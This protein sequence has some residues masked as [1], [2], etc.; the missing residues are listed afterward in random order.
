MTERMF[1][2]PKKRAIIPLVFAIVVASLLIIATLVFTI[3]AAVQA[4]NYKSSYSGY[5]SYS[6]Y[7]SYS[8]IY[9]MLP[10][11]TFSIYSLITM[12]VVAPILSVFHLTGALDEKNRIAYMRQNGLSPIDPPR[13]KSLAPMIEAGILFVLSLIFSV[14]GA[15][16]TGWKSYNWPAFIGFIIVFLIYSI[17][18]FVIACITMSIDDHNYIMATGRADSGASYSYPPA[19]TQGYA[20]QQYPVT[21]QNY[22]QTAPVYGQQA[23]QSEVPSTNYPVN[24]Q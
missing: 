17:M 24:N 9:D 10:F 21:Y 11:A 23:Y 8:D 4:S 20:V 5:S 18:H 22:Q 7:S 2:M 12:F 14:F 19:Y 3:M 6:R 13:R 1:I 15:A 16:V